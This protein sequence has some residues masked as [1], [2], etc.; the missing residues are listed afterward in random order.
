MLDF[1]WIASSCQVNLWK[2]RAGLFGSRLMLTRI[3]LLSCGFDSSVGRALHRNRRGHGFESHSEPEFF[4]RSL[5]WKCYGRTCINDRYHSIATMGQ[6]TFIFT[7]LG[8]SLNVPIY[9]G[10][11]HIRPPSCCFDSSVG[12]ALHRHCRVRGFE[13]FSGLC[14]GS[15]MAAL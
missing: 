1:V 2:N 4:F 9:K 5:F 8:P 15:V 6:I 13:F 14:F 10:L 3:R 7:V 12:R 11:T